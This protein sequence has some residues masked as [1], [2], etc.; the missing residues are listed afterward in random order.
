MD[1]IKPKYFTLAELL[2]TSTGLPNVPGSW[3]IL[4]NLCHTALTLDAIRAEYGAPIRVTSGYRSVAVNAAVGGSRTSV[5]C[6]GL[7]ADIQSYKYSKSNMVRL[8]QLLR[9]NLAKY[10]IDQLI[11]YT[12]DGTDPQGSGIIKWI[13]VGF[14]ERPRYQLL[15][16]KG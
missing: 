1:F 12:T 7:A 13:H 14:S 11:L 8:A 3:D 16:K 4:E 5:H 9:D 6:R 2:V 10:A 15:F